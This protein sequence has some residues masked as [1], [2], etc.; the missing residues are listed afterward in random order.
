[1]A[2]PS[3][4]PL[5]GLCL[6]C[7]NKLGSCGRPQS[8]AGRTR[9]LEAV[10]A[11]SMAWPC[12]PCPALGVQGD[13]DTGV[14]GVVPSAHLRGEVGGRKSELLIL[15]LL[16]PQTAGRQRPLLHPP[17]GP[18]W[19]EGAES[20]VSA[21]GLLSSRSGRSGGSPRVGAPVPMT[22]VRPVSPRASQGA[23]TGPLAGRSLPM[24]WP[25]FAST[26]AR[27]HKVTAGTGSP[28]GRS[29]P[30]LP[31]A[32]GPVFC[33]QRAKALPQKQTRPKCFLGL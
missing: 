15:S 12:A 21:V 23:D 28:E 10:P 20:P 16:F 31:Q 5:R 3:K 33:Q 6:I 1:M 26:L 27:L 30:A 13:W 24:T 25:N 7:R 4:V 8:G 2:G 29:D 32:S 11:P 9:L 18:V 17:E 22:Q 14:G 19:A